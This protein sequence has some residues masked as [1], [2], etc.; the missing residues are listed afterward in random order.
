MKTTELHTYTCKDGRVRCYD[1]KTHRVVSY[2][3]KLMEE[4]LGRPLEPY[5]QIHHI[6]GD[7]QNNDLSNLELV[8]LGEHQKMHMPNKYV[9]QEMIC[10]ECGQT[11]IW[12]AAQQRYFRSSQNKRQHR[13]N[14]INLPFCSK[15]CCGKYVRRE[16]LRRDSQSE[17][18][19]NGENLIP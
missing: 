14:P 17:C 10:P 6:D 11:F 15:G 7:P 18:G 12:T 3:R 13:A 2:P 8:V 1:P 4:K 9:D 16:Q 5:E 19:L